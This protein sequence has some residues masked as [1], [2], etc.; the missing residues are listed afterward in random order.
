MIHIYHIFGFL[1]R[2]WSIIEVFAPRLFF[3]LRASTSLR[4]RGADYAEGFE[5]RKS[6]YKMG[7]RDFDGLKTGPVELLVQYGAR[8]AKYAN[9]ALQE[10]F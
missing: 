5:T 10:S 7:F 1:Q 3:S 9:P 4:Q 6:F 2:N 8:N